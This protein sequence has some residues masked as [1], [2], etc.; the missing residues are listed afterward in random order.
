M[1]FP[2]YDKIFNKFLHKYIPMAAI[3]KMADF[4]QIT[5]YPLIF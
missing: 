2:T 1:K 3:F 5:V 4:F